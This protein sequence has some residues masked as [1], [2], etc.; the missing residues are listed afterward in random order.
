MFDRVVVG[1]DGAEGGRD[2]IVLAQRLL[3]SDGELTLAHIFSAEVHAWRG[4]TRPSNSHRVESAR[5]ILE[6]E[7]ATTG[8]EAALRWHGAPSVGR[9]LHELTE[10]TDT[11]L[12]VVGSSRRGLLGRA[13]IGDDTRAALNGAPCAVAV[14]PAGYSQHATVLRNI[15]VGYDGSPESRH[16]LRVA[17]SLAREHWS[18][19]SAL[20]AVWLPSSLLIG[21]APDGGVALEN[22]LA[23][24]RA[25]IA[26][27]DDVEPHVAYGRAAE[28]LALYGASLDLLVVGSRSYGP[29]GRLIHGATSQQLARNCRCPLL[30]LPRA[31]VDA[32]SNASVPTASSG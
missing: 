17:R 3:A 24:A 21:T 8:V 32:E 25:E 27:H 10:E 28:E 2:A 7:R 30:M 16:A 14:S 15:G 4:L 13:L 18:R 9:G 29:L 22:M 31:A 20:H 12:L 5:A 19:L 1:V 11:D 26:A 23:E 6:R